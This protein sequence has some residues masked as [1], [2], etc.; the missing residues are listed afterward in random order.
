MGQQQEM[1]NGQTWLPLLHLQ[2]IIIYPLQRVRKSTKYY[3]AYNVQKVGP[4]LLGSYCLQ[5]NKE[6]TAVKYWPA[7]ECFRSGRKEEDT[8]RLL[9]KCHPAKSNNKKKAGHRGLCLCHD[10]GSIAL[11]CQGTGSPGLS[12]AIKSLLE[13]PCSP[14]FPGK[15]RISQQGKRFLKAVQ[16]RVE[17]QL[18]SLRKVVRRTACQADTFQMFS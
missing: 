10:S 17:H 7:S 15:S 13:E 12:F 11:S 8:E 18:S 14:G 9:A 6:P 3:G 5:K 4:L 16:K 2:Q 1:V